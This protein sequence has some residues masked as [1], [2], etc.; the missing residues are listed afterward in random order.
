[1]D[2]DIKRIDTTKYTKEGK[3]DVDGN[4]WTVVLPGAGTEL[5]MSKYQ[6]RQKFLTTKIDNGTAT[7]ADLDYFD[8]IEE[9]FFNFFKSIFNDGTKDNKSVSDWVDNTPMAII[10][11]AFEDIKEQADKIEE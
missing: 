1:M 4:I 5:K 2:N 3:V 9:W 7:E 11:K 6:R 10:I 8:E